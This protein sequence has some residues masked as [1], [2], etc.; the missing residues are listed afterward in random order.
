MAV[1]TQTAAPERFRAM[2]KAGDR[3]RAFRAALR[4][5]RRVR[6]LRI[7]LPIAALATSGLYF[8]PSQIKIK[9]DAGTLTIKSFDPSKDGLKMTNPRFSGVNEKFGRY[10]IQAKTAI[11]NVKQLEFVTLNEITGNLTSAS[12]QKTL[13][14]A[15]TG[16]FHTKKKELIFDK[17]VEITGEA[18]IYAKL[19][20]A[21]A[22]FQEHI[23]MSADPVEMSYHGSTIKAMGMTAHTSESRIVFTG[24]VQVHLERTPKE[25]EK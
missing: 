17:G 11:Q 20:T 19:K 16:L 23:L 15:P 21:T 9:T 12:E 4:H 7:L 1:Q 13:L 22:Y 10:D 2:P 24:D 6:V 18:G 14:N 8:L 5:S 25:N 3:A